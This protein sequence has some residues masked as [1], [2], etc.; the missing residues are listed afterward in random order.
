MN[1]AAPP[2]TGLLV[3]VARPPE[4]AAPLARRLE[5]LGAR[6][7][8]QPPFA[9]GPPPDPAAVAAALARLADFD[10]LVF[11]SQT[12]VR[13]FLDALAQQ[14]LPLSAAAACRRAAIG[15]A[16]AAALAAAGLPPDLVP[17][18][19]TSEGLAALLKERAAGQRLLL[20]RADRG[21]DVLRRELD[22]IAAVEE[23]ACYAQLETPALEPDVE[24]AARG[25]AID[26]VLLTSQAGAAHTLKLLEQALGE[27]PRPRLIA[28]SPITAAAIAERG[29]KTEAVARCATAEGLIEALRQAAAGRG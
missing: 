15:P 25:G 6:V 14:G 9:F 4:Q 19:H 1:A 5:A 11:V 27:R 29:W 12:G 21:R 8:I 23:V 10:R 20:L 2:L 24:A 26:F 13:A 16:T 18:E 17:A 22:A 3:L 28:L 7:L